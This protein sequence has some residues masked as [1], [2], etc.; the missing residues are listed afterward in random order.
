MKGLLFEQKTSREGAGPSRAHPRGRGTAHWCKPASPSPSRPKASPQRLDA[1]QALC[2][3]LRALVSCAVVSC[4]LLF[5]AFRLSSP[6]FASLSRMPQC[7]PRFCWEDVAA[8]QEA[9]GY[10]GRPLSLRLLFSLFFPFFLDGGVPQQLTTSPAWDMRPSC[11][12]IVVIAYVWLYNTPFSLLFA[13]GSGCH[14]RSA[15]SAVSSSS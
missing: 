15:H 7:I 6:C 5:P 9:L 8:Y 12:Y 14:A 1:G 3:T 2:F 4:G 10:A 13:V 11:T